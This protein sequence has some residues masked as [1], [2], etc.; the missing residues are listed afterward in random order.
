[1]P[2]SDTL[3]GLNLLQVGLPAADLAAATAFY[4][5]V[6]GLPFLFEVSDMVFFQLG[7]TRLML[8]SNAPDLAPGAANVL[9]IDAPDLP[10]LAETLEAKGVV[11]HHPAQVLQRTDV[12]DLMLRPFSDPHGN[13]LALMGVVPRA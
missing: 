3:A 2:T 1:M 4:R 12:G 10:A 8:G 6:L 7:S 5:D 13:H 11:F 9:Y